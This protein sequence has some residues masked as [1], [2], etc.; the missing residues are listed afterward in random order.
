MN[1][2]AGTETSKSHG[3]PPGARRLVFLERRNVQ[4]QSV[5]I[6]HNLHIPHTQAACSCVYLFW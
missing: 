2:L 3:V 6:V 4:C 5:P 1:A